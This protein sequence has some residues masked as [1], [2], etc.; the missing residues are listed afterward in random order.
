MK[1]GKIYILE[2]TSGNYYIGSSTEIE[3]RWAQH[4]SGTGAAACK[5]DKP[6]KIVY[7]FDSRLRENKLVLYIEDLVTLNI[8]HRIGSH[9]VIGGRYLTSDYRR[10]EEKWIKEEHNRI[11]TAYEHTQPISEYLEHRIKECI[12]KIEENIRDKKNDK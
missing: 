3:R 12:S 4:K 8:M 6:I 9:K 5:R 1:T 2:L 10:A 11:C 7:E